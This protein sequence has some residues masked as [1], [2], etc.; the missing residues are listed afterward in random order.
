MTDIMSKKQMID[1]IR[2]NPNIKVTHI[3]FTA[4]E[5]IYYSNGK[6]FDENGYI[7]DDFQT[8]LYD[9]LRTRCGGVWESGWSIYYE[10][11]I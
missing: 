1:F 7:F 8:D 5:Y 11:I 10:V 4:N 9:G 3:L 6:V 2:A